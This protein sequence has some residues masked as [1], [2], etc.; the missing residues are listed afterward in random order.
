MPDRTKH[1]LGLLLGTE[2]DWPRAFETLVARLGP[3]RDPAG[4]EH[5]LATERIT[6]EPF[7]LRAKPRYD[8]V[9]D[10][11]AYWYYVPRE[12]LKKVALMDDVYLLNSPFTFQSM[13][14][15]AAYC[16][17][18]RLGLKVPPTWLV[19]YKNPVDH[20]KY[21]YTAAKYNE[22][23]DLDAVAAEVGYPLFMKPYDGGAWRGVSRITDPAALHKAYDSSG[24]MLM[25]L[26][27]SV[28]GYDSFARSLTI[29]PETMV[30]RF[31]PEKPMHERYAVQH[32][33]LSPDAGSEVVSI[34][35]LINA[36]FRWEFN[37]C[38]SLVVG[39]EVYPIDYANAC[40]DIS[41]TSLHYYFP[42]AIGA[43][44]KWSVFCAVTGRRARLDL[45][46]RNYF[47]VADSQLDYDAKLAEYRK[48][49][50]EYFD[51]AAYHEFCATSLPNVDNMVRDWVSSPDFDALLVDTVRTTYP[52]AEHDRFV[53]HFRGLIGL[54]IQEG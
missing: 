52:P 5:A 11:L 48:L 39:E 40:P 35:R 51:T 25:H 9:I 28:E 47:E 36:F 34:S 49:A 14:K 42:W 54:W 10:R 1:L 8:L 4:T 19:P 15:H 6:V 29:G 44:L 16:A 43:L 38:E 12:W 23:F 26:Q 31:Q 32:G 37:S 18:M 46:T 53:A 7:D 41:I 33:F 27:A 22:P 2:E 24:E 20:A 3:V 50:D 45:D 30:M 21:A 17:M 13:E